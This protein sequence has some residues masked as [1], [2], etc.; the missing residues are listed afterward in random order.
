MDHAKA[1]NQS[2]GLKTDILTADHR[3]LADE[4]LHIGGGNEGPNP[5]ELLAGS[6]AAC[7]AITLRMYV[8]HKKLPIQKIE[9]YVKLQQDEKNKINTLC[10]SIQYDGNVDEIIRKR[11]LA[12]A[13]SCPIHKVLS[14]EIHI[15]T[16]LI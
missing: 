10:R 1:I 16:N 15:Q 11:L 5:F 14:G 4:P 7:T 12:V 9:V 6:L 13:N 2:D 3:L 8:R